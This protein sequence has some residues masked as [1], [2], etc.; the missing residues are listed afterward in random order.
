MP[1]SG[2]ELRRTGRLTI[3]DTFAQGVEA[4]TGGKTISQLEQDLELTRALLARTRLELADIQ[5]EREAL[6]H[7]AAPDA[8][9]LGSIRAAGLEERAAELEAFETRLAFAAAAFEVSIKQRTDGAT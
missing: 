6:A 7:I 5:S 3:F 4:L 1:I 8:P 2:D 9:D